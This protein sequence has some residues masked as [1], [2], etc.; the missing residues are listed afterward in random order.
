VADGDVIGSDIIL[1]GVAD[2]ALAGTLS[3]DATGNYVK[4][5][6]FGGKDAYTRTDAVYSIWW[7]PD[8][9][10]WYISP[11]PGSY[12]PGPSGWWK[13]GDATAAGTYTAF[14][15]GASGSPV[16]TLL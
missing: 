1:G 12:L 11:T 13:Q 6:A 2:L 10:A 15:A 8:D 5:G 4:N 3:P 14:G 16:A 9:H 7:A